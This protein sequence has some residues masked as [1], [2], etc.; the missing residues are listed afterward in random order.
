MLW[1]GSLDIALLGAWWWR[2]RLCLLRLLLRWIL[3]ERSV[4]I[5]E[6]LKPALY[7]VFLIEGIRALSGG[8]DAVG[9]FLTKRGR[10]LRACLSGR[11][12]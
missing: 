4:L 1:W 11:R 9:V 2:L 12:G 8:R 10:G 3:I 5:Q 6:F 7:F